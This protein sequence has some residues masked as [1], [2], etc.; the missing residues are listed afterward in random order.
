MIVEHFDIT[1]DRL[2]NRERNSTCSRY[3]NNVLVY[4]WCPLSVKYHVLNA[5]TVKCLFRSRNFTIHV[6]TNCD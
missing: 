6:H 2:L 4:K 5:I 1:L 3:S